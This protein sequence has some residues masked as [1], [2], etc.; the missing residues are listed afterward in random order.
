MSVA[1]VLL[2]TEEEEEEQGQQGDVIAFSEAGVQLITTMIE[3]DQRGKKRKAPGIQDTS[4]SSSP[5]TPT[6]GRVIPKCGVCGQ[7]DSKY[8]CPRCNVRSC[9]LTCCKRHKADSNCNGQ[10]D[11]TAFVSLENF[12]DSTLCSDL[13][14]LEEGIGLQENAHSQER[15]RSNK[16]RATK[17]A[18]ILQEQAKTRSNI[19]L[20]LLPGGMTRRKQNTSF[21]QFKTQT[22]FWRVEWLFPDCDQRLHDDRLAEGTKIRD[23]LRE[24]LQTATGTSSKSSSDSATEVNKEDAKNTLAKL[25]RYNDEYTFGKLSFLMRV[26]PSRVRSVSL[27][28]GFSFLSRKSLTNHKHT[29]K[30][31]QMHRCITSLMAI[32]LSKSVWKARQS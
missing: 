1:Q 11:V 12:T 6:S 24:K 19:T 4:A 13:A 23:A 27:L 28:F 17:R 18:M 21:Y 20:R 15:Q 10:R 7:A 30:N 29:K 31:R 26:E 9:S 25:Q 16:D 2:K 32:R 3:K 14:F 8:C 5:T 22:I